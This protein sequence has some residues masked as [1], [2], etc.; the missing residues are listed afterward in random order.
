MDSM[1]AAFA[2][3]FSRPHG[4]AHGPWSLNLSMELPRN[5]NQQHRERVLCSSGAEKLPL[6]AVPRGSNPPP[7]PCTTNRH[8]IKHAGCQVSTYTSAHALILRWA[9]VGGGSQRLVV[10]Q[11]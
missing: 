4:P 7:P 11:H 6:C 5:P 2:F 10:V 1:T 3:E 9:A 8:R